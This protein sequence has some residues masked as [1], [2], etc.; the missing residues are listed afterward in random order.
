MTSLFV[1]GL[2]LAVAS[3][4]ARR[5]YATAAV[6]AVFM[7]LPAATEIVRT[8]TIGPVRKYARL[9]HP[10]VILT[11]FTNWLFDVQANRRSIVSRLDLPGQAY[12]YMMVVVIVLSVLLLVRRYKRH[13]A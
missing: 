9:G 13:S 12:F 7:L 5:A 11:G 4:A 8:L 2:S 3:L 10:V 6:I 1:A